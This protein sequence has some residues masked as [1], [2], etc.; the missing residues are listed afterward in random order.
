VVAL[1]G[2]AGEGSRAMLTKK[3]TCC[4]PQPRMMP[5]STALLESKTR[6]EI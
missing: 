6:N 3:P 4:W 5:Q 2:G 1:D